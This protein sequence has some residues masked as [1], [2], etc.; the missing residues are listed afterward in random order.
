MKRNKYIGFFA[1]LFL[2]GCN[3]DKNNA[4][5]I[6]MEDFAGETGEIVQEVVDT[7]I[8]DS[9]AIE[10]ILNIFINNQLEGFDTLL[11]TKNHPIDRFSF[12][13]KVKVEFKSKT[14]VEYGK[15]KMV[16]PRADFFYYS[17]ADSTKTKNAF[18]N[19]LDCF[20]GE[21][22]K[23]KLNEDFKSLKMPPAFAVVYDTIIVV[24]N[25]R[26]E[27]AKFNWKPFEKSI[28][29]EFGKN[30]RHKFSVGCGGPL[31]WN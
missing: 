13:Q 10:G 25:Y 12:N 21:C 26:C 18:Y 20:G 11:H 5:V 27:D 8:K 6:S 19:W 14:E 7:T 29:G 17:F 23:V 24:A 30:Y 9:V 15:D 4:E 2:I 28:I 3:A 16:T 22:D 31:T 1:I